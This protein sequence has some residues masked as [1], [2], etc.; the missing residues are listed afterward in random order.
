MSRMLMAVRE[1]GV[2]RKPSSLFELDP[3]AAL[4]KSWLLLADLLDSLSTFSASARGLWVMGSMP[5]C[6][7]FF[8]RDE[9]HRFLISLSVLPGSCAAI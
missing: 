1:L 4:G 3:E 5:L 9:F 6:L 7:S 8:L 2:P